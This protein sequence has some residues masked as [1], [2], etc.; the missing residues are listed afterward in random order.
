[1]ELSK[2]TTTVKTEKIKSTIAAVTAVVS[3]AAVVIKAVT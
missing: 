2:L 1:M 3:L